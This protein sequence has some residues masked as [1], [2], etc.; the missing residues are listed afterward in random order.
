V[1][2]TSP[3]SFDSGRLGVDPGEAIAADHVVA[4][5]SLEV[6]ELAGIPQRQHGFIPTDVGMNVEGLT[7]VWAAG[8]ATWTPI[9]QGGLAAQQ[10]DVAAA[11]I[12]GRAG[13]DVAAIG[14]RPTLNAALL[15]GTLPRYF[16]SQA[17]NPAASETSVGSTRQP[18]DK[19]AG[20][21]IA[22]YLAQRAKRD[23]Q[24]SEVCP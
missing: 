8:D 15:T 21:F 18:Q 17:W 12:A 7:H 24:A 3:V 2:G 1:T 4:L 11:A 19:I 5:P 14:Y 16:R 22:P 13:F 9:K 10:A 6:P 23:E 20:R